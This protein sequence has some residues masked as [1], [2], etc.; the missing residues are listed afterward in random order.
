MRAGSPHTIS[1][2]EARASAPAS[3]W[4]IPSSSPPLSATITTG[5]PVARVARMS[6]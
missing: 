6:A 2:T 5:R 3:A 4:A 1:S